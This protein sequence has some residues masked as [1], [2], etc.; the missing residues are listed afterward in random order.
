MAVTT[1]WDMTA[2]ADITDAA[3]DGCYVAAEALL[4]RS[5]AL[6]PFEE[7][8]LQASGFARVDESDPLLARVAYDMPY[9]WRQHEEL[10]YEHVAGRSAKYLE[11]PVNEF[12]AEFLAIVG[13]SIRVATGG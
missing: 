2:I 6:A 5:N 4:A 7:G 12:G 1:A 8:I 9:A 11:N 13:Q 3:S 10:D